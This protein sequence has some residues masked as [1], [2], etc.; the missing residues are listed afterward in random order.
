MVRRRGASDTGCLGWLLFIAIVTYAGVHIAAPYMRFYRFRDAVDQQV[1]YAA[2]RNDAGIRKEISSAADS[3]GLPEEAYHV[4]VE[5]APSA[6]RIFGSYDDSWQLLR[7]RR[8]VHFIL[9]REGPL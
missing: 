1:R 3:L 4:T 9:D 2:F 8:E 6:I 5:R 7:Y